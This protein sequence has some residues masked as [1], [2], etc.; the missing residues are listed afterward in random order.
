MLRLVDRLGSAV[1][2]VQV[3]F[4]ATM[5]TVGVGAGDRNAE[6]LKAMLNNTETRVILR[7]IS[8]FHG[9]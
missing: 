4:G 9:D 1:N 5:L 3:L 6:E 2:E 7:T 8:D